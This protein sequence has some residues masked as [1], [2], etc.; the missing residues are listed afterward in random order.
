MAKIT[1][2]VGK[3]QYYIIV[4]L[5]EYMT[6]PDVVSCTNNILSEYQRMVSCSIPVQDI[7]NHKI[8]TAE[9]YTH[10]TIPTH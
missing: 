7:T 6:R 9:K 10:N 5:E 3:Q 2:A 1:A 4:K 8:N